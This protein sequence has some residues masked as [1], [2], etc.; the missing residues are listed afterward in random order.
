MASYVCFSSDAKESL[1]LGLKGAI[2]LKIRLYLGGFRRN[3]L[4][5]LLNVPCDD[6]N[7]VFSDPLS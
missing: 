2:D 6:C 5:W 4:R 1:P 3:A 7:T